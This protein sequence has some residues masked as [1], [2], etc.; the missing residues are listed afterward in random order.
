[1]KLNFVF[2]SDSGGLINIFGIFG[3]FLAYFLPQPA[4]NLAF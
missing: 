2:L 1:M 4:S 3:S